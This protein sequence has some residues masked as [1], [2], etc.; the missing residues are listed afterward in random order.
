MSLYD[1][2]DSGKKIMTRGMGRVLFMT[3]EHEAMHAETLLYMLLQRAGTGTL[4]PPGFSPPLWESLSTSWNSTPGTNSKMVILGPEDISLGHDDD[5]S[6]DSSPAS[7]INAEVRD[8][9]F[10]WDNEHPRRVVHVDKFAIEWR[11]VTNGEFYAFYKNGKEKL[12]YPASWIK[13]NGVT[14]VSTAEFHNEI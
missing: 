6:A 11:P 12:E 14:K 5:E 10:G 2:I 1:D 13:E 4:P 8:H 3:L 9:E 7:N